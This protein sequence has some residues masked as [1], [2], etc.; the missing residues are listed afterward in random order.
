MTIIKSNKFKKEVDIIYFN[1]DVNDLI[2]EI[3]DEFAQSVITSPP[4]NLGKE[5]EKKL[6]LD[7]Y[8]EQ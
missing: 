3:P 2:T 4:Y 8:L 7:I 6:S 5:Y 1:G